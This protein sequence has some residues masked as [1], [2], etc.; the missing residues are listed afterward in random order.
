MTYPSNLP[1]PELLETETF[2]QVLSR[3]LARFRQQNPDYTNTSASDPAVTVLDPAAYENVQIRAY[4]TE[5]Y[6]QLLVMFATGAALDLR[7]ADVG[8]TRNAN[9]SDADLRLRIQLQWHS[10]SGAGTKDWYLSKALKFIRMGK[11]QSDVKDMIGKKRIQTGVGGTAYL[12]LQVHKGDFDAIHGILTEASK[13]PADPSIYT[14]IGTFTYRDGIPTAASEIATVRSANLGNFTFTTSTPTDAQFGITGSS[15]NEKLKFGDA[16]AALT[17]TLILLKGNGG[18]LAGA[19]ID[20]K[21]TGSDPIRIPLNSEYDDLNGVTVG[22]RTGGSLSA[23]AYSLTLRVPDPIHSLC[24]TTP[25][26]GAIQTA[27][28]GFQKGDVLKISTDM[29]VRLNTA[30]TEDSTDTGYMRYTFEIIDILR[31]ES[32]VPDAADSVELKRASPGPV[33]EDLDTVQGAIGGQPNIQYAQ[34]LQDY[35]SEKGNRIICD[36]VKV[37]G[38]QAHTY[39]VTAT[40]GIAEGNIPDAVKATAETALKQFVE[41]AENISQPLSISQFYA[42]LQVSGVDIVTLT[43]PTEANLTGIDSTDEQDVANVPVAT[44]ITLTT[45]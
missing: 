31:A 43:A 5:V 2:E 13:P 41:A 7:A 24:I 30:P 17:D 8:L 37:K 1:L 19:V 35:L 9:E 16:P 21:K 23:G 15:P 39:T 4:V 42:V 38:V 29:Y 14:D 40:L 10:L 28:A 44:Q 6:R 33:L 26:T 20:A 45:A 34:A 22:A 11:S 36:T 32:S 3:M 27:V 25:T 12:Y 18:R